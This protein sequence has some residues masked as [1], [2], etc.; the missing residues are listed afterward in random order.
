MEND[1]LFVQAAAD[2]K[3]TK[4]DENNNKLKKG[5]PSSQTENESTPNEVVEMVTPSTTK[6]TEMESSEPNIIQETEKTKMTTTT[7]I[8]DENKKESEES[9]NDNSAE[10]KRKLHISFP[11]FHVDII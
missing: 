8:E 2:D 6:T 3:P 1:G 10:T 9:A 7:K 11:T 4:L 5:L